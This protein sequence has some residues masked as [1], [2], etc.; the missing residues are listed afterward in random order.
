MLDS[1]ILASPL[2][3]VWLHC[4]AQHFLMGM[5]VPP[6]PLMCLFN[7]DIASMVGT[8]AQAAASI[9]ATL[10]HQLCRWLP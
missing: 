7:S 8:T 2:L 1:T 4:S 10:L 6:F 9:R 3:I 5:W